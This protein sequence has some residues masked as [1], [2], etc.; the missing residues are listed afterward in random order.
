MAPRIK[1]K[2][3]P[4]DKKII[5]EK[6]EKVVGGSTTTV[7]STSISSPISPAGSTGTSLGT[8]VIH[9]TLGQDVA[10]PRKTFSKT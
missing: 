4:Q 3:L 8:P 6:L 5:K 7:F 9:T 2:D 10:D 1:I